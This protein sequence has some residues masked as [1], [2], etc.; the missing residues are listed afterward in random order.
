[1]ERFVADP[2][3]DIVQGRCVVFNSNE[4]LL[5]TLVSVEFDKIYNVSHP[6]RA[7]MW[8]FGLFC[9]SNGYWKA[10]LLKEH[11]MDGDMLCEDIDSALRACAKGRK[12][13]HELNAVSYELAPTHF[14]AFWKQR[15]R[16]AQGWTQASIRHLKMTWNRVQCDNEE[17]RTRSA[18]V[19][20]GIFSL[21]LIREWSYYLVTQYF[22]LTISFVILKFPKSGAQ[23][24]ALVFFQYPVSQWLFFIR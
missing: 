12:A 8:G 10:S 24:W 11:K 13:V 14:S 15:L 17:Q 21:L 19:R 5:T 2:S 6:G 3:I 22:C 23:L 20:F 1:M 16:W 18:R 4:T 7:A 9:G